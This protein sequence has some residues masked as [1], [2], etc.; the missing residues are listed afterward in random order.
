MQEGAG[1]L[2]AC[3]PE[4]GTPDALGHSEAAYFFPDELES[5][6]LLTKPFSI[7]E[8]SA[9]LK[10][11]PYDIKCALERQTPLM[12]SQTTNGTTAQAL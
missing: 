1:T 10:S 6:R 3:S 4:S 5:S 7:S 8:F 12:N 9:L 2:A 11:R